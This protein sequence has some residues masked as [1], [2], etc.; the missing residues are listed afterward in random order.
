MYVQEIRKGIT[1]L[2]PD[3]ERSL[4]TDLS[5]RHVSKRIWSSFLYELIS[6]ALIFASV[7]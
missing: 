6:A 2:Q 5:T 3:W 1:I 7:L 4:S